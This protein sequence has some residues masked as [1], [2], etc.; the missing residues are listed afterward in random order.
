MKW[1]EFIN[2]SLPLPVLGVDDVFLHVYTLL[3]CKMFETIVQ[4]ILASQIDAK[5]T[6]VVNHY[7]VISEHP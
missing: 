3:Q 4:V 2:Q 5:N 1:Y 7:L 6:N